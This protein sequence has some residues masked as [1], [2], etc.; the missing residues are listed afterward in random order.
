MHFG[1]QLRE[2]LPLTNKPIEYQSH[3]Q[4]LSFLAGREKITAILDF[5]L[6][7]AK[8]IGFWRFIVESKII[9]LDPT[10]N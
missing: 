8:P 5:L 9:E 6:R 3:L 7:S 2:Y 1:C 4:V 10:L